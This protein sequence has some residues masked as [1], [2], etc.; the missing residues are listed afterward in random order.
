MSNSLLTESDI[1]YLDELRLWI[2]GSLEF[3]VLNV[4][5]VESD[6]VNFNGKVPLFFKNKVRN[7]FVSLGKLVGVCE[8]A[9]QNRMIY[10]SWLQSVLDNIYSFSRC[11]GADDF[12]RLLDFFKRYHGIES[13]R[14]LAE[15][16][17]EALDD[18][19]KA[20]YG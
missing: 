2:R 12:E 10:E 7:G 9:G 1:A 8:D 17:Q 15:E 4:K 5:P 11:M 18:A 20:L 16:A 13:E 6:L 3:S 19:M 14:A